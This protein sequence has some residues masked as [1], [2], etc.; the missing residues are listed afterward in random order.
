MEIKLKNIKY[1]VT[2]SRASKC[3]TASIYRNTYRVGAASNDGS[4]QDT[5]IDI[6]NVQWLEEMEYQCEIMDPIPNSD[7]DNMPPMSMTL[8]RYIDQMVT[9]FVEEKA[10]ARA[11]ARFT[12]YRLAG[13][14]YL[15]GAWLRLKE[16][17]SERVA[18]RLR[19]RYGSDLGEILN[20]TR[21]AT[22][23]AA[24]SRA[25]NPSR[26]VTRPITET[27]MA[28]GQPAGSL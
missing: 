5:Q 7:P 26:N 1:L 21:A 25:L 23:A 18:G 11:C 10:L 28:Y 6:P 22:E 16:P 3:Y 13:S 15:P 17:Y 9:A 2:R 12:L 24:L 14:S 4:G 27:V 19:L 20:E 8:G